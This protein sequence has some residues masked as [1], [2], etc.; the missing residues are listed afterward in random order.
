MD[1]NSFYGGIS[2]I[3]GMAIMGLGIYLIHEWQNKGARHLIF[4]LA[5]SS[6]WCVTYGMELLSSDLSTK[7]IWVRLEYFGAG[8]VALLLCRFILVTTGKLALLPRWV[9]NGLWVIPI[10]IILSAFTNQWHHLLWR[11]AWLVI[12][13]GIQSVQYDRGPFFW[14]HTAYSYVLILTGFLVLVKEAITSTGTHRMQVLVMLPGITVPWVVNWIYLGGIENASYID[15]SPVAFVVTCM[16]FAL[17]LYRYHLLNLIPLA[18][19]A[20][21]DGLG[22]PVIVMDMDDRVA[23]VNQACVN[24]FNLDRFPGRRE[25]MKEI[26][27]GVYDVVKRSRGR[28][29]IEFEMAMDL[30]GRQT[31]LWH[32]RISPLWGRKRIQSGWLVVLRDITDE[33]KGEKALRNAKDYVKSIINSMPSMLIGVDRKGVVTQWNHGVCQVTGVSEIQAAGMMLTKIFPQMIPFKDDLSKAMKTREIQRRE[34]QVLALDNHNLIVDIIIFP[35]TSQTTPGAVIRI[36]DISEQTKIREMIIQSEKMMS[37]GGLAAG[38]AHEINNPLSGMIQNILVIKNRLSRKLPGNLEV[39]GKHGIDLDRLKGYMKDRKIF[40]MLDQAVDVG[41][42]AAKIVDN[43][44]SF[45]R[46]HDKERSSHSIPEIVDAAVSLLENDFNLKRYYDFKTIDIIRKAQDDLP[47]VPCEK[48]KIQQVIFNILKN[49]VQAMT[50][51]NRDNKEEPKFVIR[52]FL[53]G[54]M[55]GVEIKDNGPGIEEEVRKRIFEPFFTTK[56]VGTGTG[57]G[58]SVSYF[59]VVENHKGELTVDSNPGQGASF[60]IK[61]PLG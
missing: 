9:V 19:E 55:A 1:W 48:S 44:L 47:L 61:L 31:R 56:S 29:A 16:F 24:A 41:G 11:D 37:V 6:I 20:V 36:D 38:M 2:F 43:M 35:V 39:A 60:T 25:P 57:L 22:D 23:E 4:L 34:K 40:Y 27:P 12:K 7:L 50:L 51:N 5:A 52:Y 30:T 3:S 54:K 53:D 33:K 32:I 10:I 26:F 21:M 18:H 42:R 17:G 28:Q 46:K 8:T 59:I 15:L 14:L 45:S 58:L 13:P 49:G